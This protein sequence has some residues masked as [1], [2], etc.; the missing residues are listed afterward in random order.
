M[1]LAVPVAISGNYA[2]VGATGEDDAGSNNWQGI[3]F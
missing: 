3:Y 1:V 2:I